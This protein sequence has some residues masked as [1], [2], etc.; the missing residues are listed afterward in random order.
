MELV[1]ENVLDVLG[2]VMEP[3]LKKDI[4]SANLVQELK[5]EEN[6]IKQTLN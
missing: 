5:I 3:D 1:R 6:T 2:S 4:V